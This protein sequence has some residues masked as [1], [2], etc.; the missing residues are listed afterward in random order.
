MM[1]KNERQ[2]RVAKEHARRFAASVRAIEE[3]GADSLAAD[4]LIVK[5]QKDAL[6]SQ[7][8]DLENELREY[9]DMKRMVRA[10]DKLDAEYVP[11]PALAV[12]R[13][14]LGITAKDLAERVGLEER[15]I[16]IYEETSYASASVS[17]VGEVA[18]ALRACR[19]ETEFVVSERPR[20]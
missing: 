1:I 16:R 9:D 14:A 19:D 13:M 8:A 20:A 17:R 2:Y 12:A 18:S 10:L 5:A 7:L 4:P 3:G 11:P 15:E 6:A